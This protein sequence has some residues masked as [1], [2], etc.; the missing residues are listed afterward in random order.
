MLTR[1]CVGGVIFYN[2]KIFIIKNDKSEWV[3]PQSAIKKGNEISELALQKVKS[4]CGVNAELLSY[5][6]ETSFYH[7]FHSQKNRHYNLISWFLMESKT[8]EYSLNK[9]D[10]Y[11]EAGFFSIEEAIEKLSFQQ[12]KGLISYS[13]KKYQEFQTYGRKLRIVNN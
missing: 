10:G 12:H 4:E 2:N 9:T 11:M 5:L 6:G 13:Y 7:N 3:L 1:H 8:G